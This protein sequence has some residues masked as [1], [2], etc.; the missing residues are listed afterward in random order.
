MGSNPY[1]DHTFRIRY[2]ETD[3]MGVVH[4]AVYPVWFEIGR[5][6]LSHQCDFPYSKIEESGIAMAVAELTVRYKRPAK[7][8]NKVTVRTWVEKI[9]SK[10]IQFNYSVR[11]AESDEIL[12]TGHSIH[13][14]VDME[15]FRPTRLPDTIMSHFQVWNS[16]EN[17]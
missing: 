9:R 16:P 15:S 17:A 2:A 8:D 13:V 11:D 14:F 1:N 7:Y 12:A 10:M 4:N 3:Q 5:T 6:E